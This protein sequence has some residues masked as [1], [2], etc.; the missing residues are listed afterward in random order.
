MH[1]DTLQKFMFEGAPVRGELVELSDTWKQVQ[2]RRD[3][4]E[5]VNTLLGEMLAAAGSCCAK[6][7]IIALT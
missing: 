6:L 1:K 4:P 3:Y 2:S 7:G 5:A